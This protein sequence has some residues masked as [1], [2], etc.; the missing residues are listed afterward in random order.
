MSG[1]A[2]LHIGPL[3]PADAAAWRPLAE[4]YK[5]FYKTDVDDAGYAQAWARLMAGGPCRGLGAWQGGQGGPG[6]TLVG[7][8]H[9]VWH[10]ST[11]APQVIYLQDLFVDPRARGQGVGEALIAHLADLARGQG[12]ARLYWLTHSGNATARRLYDRVAVHR[13]FV[14]YDHA[15]AAAAA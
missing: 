1:G 8:A 2:P 7:I 5:A 12:A 13:G 3:R 14:C 6:G 11:W 15:L 9:T 4:G 10:A